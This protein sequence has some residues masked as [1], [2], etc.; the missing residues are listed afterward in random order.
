MRHPTMEQISRVN[1]LLYPQLTENIPSQIPME[2]LLPIHPPQKKHHHL[3]EQKKASKSPTKLKSKWN[4]YAVR[5]LGMAHGAREQRSQGRSHR[6]L[7]TTCSREHSPGGLG[8]SH[9]K[10][11]PSAFQVNTTFYDILSI[12]CAL[13]TVFSEALPLLQIPRTNFPT[14]LS[15]LRA[16]LESELLPMM[17]TL[18]PWNSQVW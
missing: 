8:D 15:G 16:N 14:I 1:T 5:P 13:F 9:R 4:F 2:H 10:W 17:L 6:D 18:C 7:T 11:C 12:F 3:L